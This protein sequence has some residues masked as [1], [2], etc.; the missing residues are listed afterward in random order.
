MRFLTKGSFVT[1]A[2]ADE[3][4]DTTDPGEGSAFA[5]L[6]L[7]PYRIYLAGHTVASTGN[8]IQSIALDWLVL[9]LAGS[10]SAV[11][12]AMACQFLPI[13]LFGM[14]GGLI[15]DRFP[16]RAVLLITQ[17]ANAAVGATIAVLTLGGAARVEILYLL[18]LVAG[19]VHL[20]DNPARQ[21]FVNEVVPPER[22]RAAIALNAAAF[23]GSRLVG[24][25]I[26]VGLIATVGTGWAFAAT[27][28]AYLLPTAGLLLLRPADLHP[29]PEFDEET[30]RLRDALRH[31]AHRPRVAAAIVLVGVVGTFGLNFPIVLTAMAEEAFGGGAGLYGLFN[32]VLAVGSVIG[33]LIATAVRRSG[34]SLL[35]ATAGGFGAAQAAAAYAPGLVVFLGLLVVTG[36][37]NLAFQAIA[38]AS[39]QAWVDPA[40]RG[41]VMGL[42]MLVFAGGTPVGAP[43]IGALTTAW[44][45][46]AGMAVCGIVPLAACAGLVVLR[47]SR[48][49]AAQS[50]AAAA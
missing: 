11:G 5:A 19:V 12:I 17:S 14:H 10:P 49:A 47:R 6:R 48:A 23:Q 26:A 36:A 34:T 32:I 25:A 33:A 30:G 42:Y 21:V 13:L 27:A 39:V 37:T 46:R 41:R 24:P 38:N 16:K 50:L 35:L 2:T 22:A 18:A 45:A 4:T 9:E 15:A 8:W 28:L 43:I 1:T 7:R 44:G 31:V 3:S 20:F 40:Q 29:A